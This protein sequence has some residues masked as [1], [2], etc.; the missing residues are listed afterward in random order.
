VGDSDRI[1]GGGGQASYQSQH[2]GPSRVAAARLGWGP[3]PRPEQATDHEGPVS[4]ALFLRSLIPRYGPHYN[5]AGSGSRTRS[6]RGPLV[7][8]P[9][10]L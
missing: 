2:D 7:C 9:Q 5:N 8:F 6:A 1:S 3:H 4:P 10:R